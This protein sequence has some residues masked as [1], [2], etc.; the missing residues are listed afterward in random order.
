VLLTNPPFSGDHK[1]RLLRF[2]RNNTKPYVLLLPAYVATK[3]Y[4]KEFSTPQNQYL[5]VS[6]PRKYSYEHPEGTGN[7]DSPFFSVWFIGGLPNIPAARRALISDQQRKKIAGQQC[8]TVLDS[9]EEMV[10]RGAAKQAD[11]RP[12]PKRRRK[13]RIEEST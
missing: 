13:N 4:W 7:E 12:N 6:P 8:C 11:K 5:Y 3:S 9:V 10:R 1:L 2:L